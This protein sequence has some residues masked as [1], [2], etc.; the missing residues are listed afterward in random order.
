MRSALTP[1]TERPSNVSRIYPRSDGTDPR[2]SNLEARVKKLEEIVAT[3]T[4]EDESAD[5]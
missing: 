3:L 4:G 2:I 1:A 5:E